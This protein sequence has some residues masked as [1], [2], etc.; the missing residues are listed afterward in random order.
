MI[1]RPRPLGFNGTVLPSARLYLGYQIDERGVEGNSGE[2]GVFTIRVHA[3]QAEP[4]V[5]PQ[6]E[7]LDRS[8]NE[9]FVAMPSFSIT[10]PRDRSRYCI[11]LPIRQA[12]TKRISHRAELD[13]FIITGEVQLAAWYSPATRDVLTVVSTDY[14]AAGNPG[15]CMSAGRRCLFGFDQL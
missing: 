10:I 14:A 15:I 3:R 2:I 8:G 12:E 1:R 13:W 5:V 4:N 6:A 9:R 11:S 7:P